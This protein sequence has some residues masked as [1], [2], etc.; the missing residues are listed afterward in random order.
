VTS[1]KSLPCETFC[2]LFH[3]C[4][5]MKTKDVQLLGQLGCIILFRK[6]MTMHGQTNNIKTCKTILR[7]TIFLETARQKILR[8]H[9]PTASTCI[10]NQPKHVLSWYQFLL[11]LQSR[12]TSVAIHPVCWA[13]CT[14]LMSLTSG[15]VMLRDYKRSVMAMSIQIINQ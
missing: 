8:S 12:K 13:T 15:H 2:C 11:L 5:I 4:V 1:A 9:C 7:T 14:L 6:Y 10:V 3:C